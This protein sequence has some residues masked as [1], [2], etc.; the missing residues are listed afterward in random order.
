MFNASNGHQCFIVAIEGPDRV[1]KATQAALLETALT[2]NKHKATVEEIPYDDGVTYKQIYAMLRSGAVNK[3]PVVF[4]TL[5]ATNRRIFQKQFLPTL[6][7]HYD[8]LILDRWNLSTRVYGEASGVSRE[9]TDLIL[10]GIVEPDVTLVFDGKP[11]PKEGLDTWEADL[12]FQRK[13]RGLYID[14][15]T[16]GRDR[17]VVKIEAAGTKEEIHEKCLGHV[18]SCLR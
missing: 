2:A 11:F 9:A 7:L 6:A 8:V 17:G 16:F 18:L 12:E 13:V 14:A 1:G 5:Q 10:E 4:Q 3:H 15:V